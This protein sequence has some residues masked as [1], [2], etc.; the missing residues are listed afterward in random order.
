MWIDYIWRKIR[1]FERKEKVAEQRARI[2]AEIDIGDNCI[3]GEIGSETKHNE[4]S[5]AAGKLNQMRKL[6]EI[7]LALG[8]CQSLCEDAGHKVIQQGEC[9]GIIQE[10]KKE[11]A[12]MIEITA[13]SL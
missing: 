10:M 6:Q 1:D 5:P 8:K 12:R 11:F 2:E 7:K 13:S 4:E 3:D 9:G